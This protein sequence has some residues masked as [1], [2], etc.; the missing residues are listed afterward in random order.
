[1]AA[2]VIAAVIGSGLRAQIS[3]NA[4]VRPLS[5]CSD[6]AMN[7]RLAT[8]QS[9]VCSRKRPIEVGV[10]VA[11][12]HRGHTQN[13]QSP[14]HSCPHIAACTMSFLVIMHACVCRRARRGGGGGG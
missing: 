10:R 8:R 7:C 9:S 2:A 5:S 4:A 11:F 14:H 1:M 13:M 6:E 12:P 3:L